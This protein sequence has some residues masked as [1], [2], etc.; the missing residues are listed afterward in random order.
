MEL[1]KKCAVMNGFLKL[2]SAI[3]LSFGCFIFVERCSR[4]I[5]NDKHSKFEKLLNKDKN[6]IHAL[7]IEL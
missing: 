3:A 4:I 5:Y 2:N 6:S 7:T 1:P